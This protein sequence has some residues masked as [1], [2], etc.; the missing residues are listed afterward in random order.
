MSNF[1]SKE[2]FREF[3]SVMYMIEIYCSWKHQESTNPCSDCL[4]L[5]EYA[6]N[7]LTK[8]PFQDSKPACRNCKIHC[9]QEPYKSKIKQV[10]RFSGP[11]ML[12]Y[13]PILAVKHLVKE[14]KKPV[15]R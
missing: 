14:F 11:L 3:L 5:I 9:Y 15:P 1:K 7:R 12:F 10:M 13:H 2:L 4:D 8:C 6:K